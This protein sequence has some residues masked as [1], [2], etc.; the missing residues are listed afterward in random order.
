MWEFVR[1]DHPSLRGIVPQSGIVS[2]HMCSQLSLICCVIILCISHSQKVN[3]FPSNYAKIPRN[4]L[5][6]P[7][8]IDFRVGMYGSCVYTVQS[9]KKMRGT[10]ATTHRVNHN[11]APA[12]PPQKI[13]IGG[14]PLPP[15]PPQLPPLPTPMQYLYHLEMKYLMRES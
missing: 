3:E 5:T 4:L 2:L 13:Y 9:C 7:S 8:F 14:N 6:C 10:I 15:P 12:R 1:S 11:I